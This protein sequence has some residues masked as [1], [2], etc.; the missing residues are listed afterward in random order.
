MNAIDNHAKDGEPE[1]VRLL[2]SFY[3]DALRS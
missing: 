1:E 3:Y 2:R